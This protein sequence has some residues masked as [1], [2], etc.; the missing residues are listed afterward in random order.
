[1]FAAAGGEAIAHQV[2]G[3][4]FAG[5]GEQPR[6]EP[7][8]AD[9]QR[10]VG[11]WG[12]IAGAATDQR[13]DFDRVA[14]LQTVLIVTNPWYQVAVDLHGHAPR[15]HPEPIEQRRTRGGFRQRLWVWL[16]P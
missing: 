13:H 12:G 1:H 9:H 6:A 2:V 8:R 5:A 10:F 7:E 4:V 15:I 11:R 16:V 3:R 14:R